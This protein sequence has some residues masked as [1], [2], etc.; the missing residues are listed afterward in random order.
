MA[1]EAAGREAEV[2]RLAEEQERSRLAAEERH[3]AE[4]SCHGVTWALSKSVFWLWPSG[5]RM[6]PMVEMRMCNVACEQKN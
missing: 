3:R 6:Q 2:L 5:R 1:A 4:V